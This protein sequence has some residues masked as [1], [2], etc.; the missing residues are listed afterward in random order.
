MTP[1]EIRD[2]RA[3]K[4]GRARDIAHSL[5]LAEAQLV[6]SEVGLSAVALEAHPN[7]LIP[8]ME[9]LGR[10]MALTRNEACVIE[11]DGEYSDYHGGEHATMTL[12]AGIELRMFPRHWRHAYA[13]EEDTD[14]GMRRSVQVFDAAGDA[15]H[16]AYLRQDANLEAWEGLRALLALSEQV[17]APALQERAATEGPKIVE[18]KRDILLKEWKRLTDTHQFL[19]L[20]AKLK[21]NRLGAYRIAGVPFV[22]AIN[23]Q[24]IPAL[25]AKV[26][27]SRIAVMIFVGNRGCIEIHTGPIGRLQ[28]MGPW[29]NVLDSEFNLHLRRDKITEVWAVEKPTQRGPALSVEAFDAEGGLIFQMFAVAKETLDTRPQWAEIVAELPSLE[30]V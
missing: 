11:K 29:E 26:Q 12:N 6:A 22:R 16:K 8:A 28:P 30:A 13:L 21:M 18:A 20:C 23:P 27:S 3:D 19:R 1:A 17:D 5:G 4:S 2:A 9:P 24:A 14:K 25:L 15:V 7:K 10:C